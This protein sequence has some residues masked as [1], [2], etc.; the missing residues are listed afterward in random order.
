[1]KSP[2]LFENKTP[3]IR[4]RPMPGEQSAPYTSAT[5]ELPPCIGCGAECIFTDG[6]CQQCWIAYSECQ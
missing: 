2:K 5:W 3:A 1:M 4:D 6:F